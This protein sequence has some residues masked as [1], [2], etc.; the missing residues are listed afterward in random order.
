MKSLFLIVFI[1]VS[2]LASAGISSIG[3][4]GGLGELQFI[5]YF[6]NTHQIIEICEKSPACHVTAEQSASWNQLKSEQSRLKDKVNISFEPTVAGSW[7]WANEKLTVSQQWLYQGQLDLLRSDAQI[8]I[9]ALAIQLSHTQHLNFNKTY[10]QTEKTFSGLS[11]YN[12]LSTNSTNTFRFHWITLSNSEN[13]TEHLKLF[14]LEDPI[15]SYSLNNLI[16]LKSKDLNLNSIEVYNVSVMNSDTEI[17]VYGSMS[18][19]NGAIYFNQ[20]PF[21]FTAGI[22]NGNLILKDSVHLFL[23]LE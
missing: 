9:F 6:N 21:K 12:Q 10:Q 2:Q 15:N 23:L 20:K 8:M 19:Y 7:S 5:Y 3:N 11:F 14:V 22:T 13:G 4:G 1:L 16:Q 18:G 17:T